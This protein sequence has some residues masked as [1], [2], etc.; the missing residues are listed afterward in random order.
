[1]Q[2]FKKFWSNKITENLIFQTNIYLV[3]KFGKCIDT[4]AL[5]IERYVGIQMLMSIIPLPS[6]ELPWLKDL[7]VDLLSI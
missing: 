1:M 3:Q 7:Q 5:E 6:Y 4:N 2:Y